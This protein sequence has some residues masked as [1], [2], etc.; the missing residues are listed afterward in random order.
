MSWHALPLALL[1][2]VA[3]Y[4]MANFLARRLAGNARIAA[5]IVWLPLPWVLHALLQAAGSE[6]DLEPMRRELLGMIHHPR[7]GWLLV[8]VWLAGNGA[9][10]AIGLRTRAREKSPLENSPSRL[11]LRLSPPRPDVD[12]ADYD[13][14]DWSIPDRK[15][16]N[17]REIEKALRELADRAGIAYQYLTP[18]GPRVGDGETVSSRNGQYI[19]DTDYRGHV[20]YLDKTRSRDELFY[21]VMTSAMTAACWDEFDRESG[22]AGEWQEHTSR[23]VCE[24]LGKLDPRWEQQFRFDRKWPPSG[25]PDVWL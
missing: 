8:L 2:A 4:Q 22:N 7:A 6:G 25:A 21:W 5:M 16:L 17:D 10:L 1:L 15:I 11:R 9:G 23:R 12:P 24:T 14:P 19:R 18:V 13:L 3:G 20:V